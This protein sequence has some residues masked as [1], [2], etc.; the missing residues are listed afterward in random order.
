M[1]VIARQQPRPLALQPLGNLQLRALRTTPMATRVVPHALGMPL[2]AR[3]H[4]A[5]QRGR[6]TTPETMHRL[7]DVHGE[8]VGPFIL[9]IVGIKEVLEDTTGHERDLPRSVW[10]LSPSAAP[11]APSLPDPSRSV[12]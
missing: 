10:V 2:R 4:V 11:P 7:T 6:A 12:P 9:G 3:L 5:P 8:R 1:L